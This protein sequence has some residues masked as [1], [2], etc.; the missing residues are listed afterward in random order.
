[1]NSSN[2]TNEIDKI[3]SSVKPNKDEREHA[4]SKQQHPSQ[5]NNLK[6][7]NSIIYYNIFLDFIL[8]SQKFFKI[9][10]SAR[11]IVSLDLEK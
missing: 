11:F 10:L 1:M 6:M 9:T 8:G 5:G 7:S 2:E 4:H 3:F